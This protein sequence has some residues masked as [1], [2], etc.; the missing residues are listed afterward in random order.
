MIYT[1]E[2]IIIIISVNILDIIGETTMEKNNS[3]DMHAFFRK[4]FQFTD[5]EELVERFAS[6]SRIV[7]LNKGDV[8]YHPG[9]GRCTTTFL[10]DG[11]LKSY[12]IGQDG[13]E[14]TYALWYKPGTAIC[15]MP[16]LVDI[17]GAWLSAL[18]PATI[19]DMANP[20][21]WELADEYPE[22]YKELLYGVGF[23][24]FGMMDKLRAGYTL[25]AKERYL[26]FLEKY[27]PI[28]DKVSQVEIASFL[29]IKPQ[30]LSRIRAELAEEGTE[31]TPPPKNLTSVYFKTPTNVGVFSGFVLI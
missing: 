31:L 24:Y 13:S 21:P 18:T 8:I 26:W 30:S 28:A 19:I 10:L 25:T 3:F 2:N 11:V 6:Q 16:K 9:M 4:F 27:G 15:T 23:M 5:N 1:F 20:G 7:T 22:L 17:P 14:N 29:G 12:I